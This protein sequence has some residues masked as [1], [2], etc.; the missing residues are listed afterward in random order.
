[1]ASAVGAPEAVALASAV[2]DVLH[3]PA[4]GG[5]ERVEACRSG[6]MT[7]GDLED[8][9]SKVRELLAEIGV[10]L[11]LFG[12]GLELS[13]D[14]IRRLWRA[15]V[16]GGAVQVSLTGLAAGLLARAAEQYVVL[17]YNRADDLGDTV[18]HA[19]ME[20]RNAEHEGHENDH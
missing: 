11:L 6:A 8:E 14:R 9:H 7:F 16:F 5:M 2:M 12:I 18:N 17:L 20:V 1:M 10:V 4:T 3:A 19:A 13:L 15:I